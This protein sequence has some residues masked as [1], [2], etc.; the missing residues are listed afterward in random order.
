MF[1]VFLQKKAQKLH[2]APTEDTTLIQPERKLKIL[3]QTVI[4]LSLKE[5]I[6]FLNIQD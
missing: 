4:A 3:Q 2:K 1:L 5:L 6:L